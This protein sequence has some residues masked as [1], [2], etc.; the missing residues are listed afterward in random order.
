MLV[1]H[2]S[3]KGEITTHFNFKDKMRLYFFKTPHT[4]THTHKNH[5]VQF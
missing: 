3:T 5:T 4:H 1:A 2:A